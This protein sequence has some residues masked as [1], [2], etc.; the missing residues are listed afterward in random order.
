MTCRHQT[1]ARYAPRHVSCLVFEANRSQDGNQRKLVTTELAFAARLDAW[2]IVDWLR[3]VEP[4][5]VGRQSYALLL[6]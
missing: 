2:A 4:A 1:V 6:V 3:I 5:T